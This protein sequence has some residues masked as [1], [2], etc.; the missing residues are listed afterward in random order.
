MK[1]LGNNSTVAVQAS[2]GQWWLQEFEPMHT[3]PSFCRSAPQLMG[4]TCRLYQVWDEPTSALLYSWSLNSSSTSS[5]N[6]S[7]GRG[8]P[9]AGVA[10][11]AVQPAP[12]R[13]TAFVR[14]IAF[15]VSA[16]GEVQLCV[17]TSSGSIK[18]CL[19]GVA[20][21]AASKPRMAALKPLALCRH[22]KLGAEPPQLV[23]AQAVPCWY[24]VQLRLRS[25]R[26]SGTCMPICFRSTDPGGAR[27]CSLGQFGGLCMHHLP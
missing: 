16:D 26:C 12:Q 18:V 10:A 1:L 19:C 20:G 4:P 14:G 13:H 3:K 2:S 7:T 25:H 15:N 24:E 22:S 11:L 23:V 27:A 8:S 5:S 17:G 6:H 21:M 9:L